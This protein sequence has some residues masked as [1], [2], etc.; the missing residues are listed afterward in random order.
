MTA[1]L[2]ASAL[3]AFL[4]DESGAAMVEQQLE[5]GAQC[6]AVNWSEV[7]Q[8]LRANGVDWGVARAVLDSYG[9]RI[10]DAT[11]Q[12]GVWAAERWRPGEGLSLAD[13]FCLALGARTGE[14]VLTA[15]TAWGSSPDV[16]QIR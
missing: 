1:V 9:L 12:D 10:V 16:R 2:D 15:D 6:S 7:V 5:A 13:R 4:Q 8:K 11:G 3:L 14:V